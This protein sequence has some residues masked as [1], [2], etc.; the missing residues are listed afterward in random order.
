MAANEHSTSSV[1]RRTVLVTI[2][3]NALAYGGL[4]FMLASFASLVVLMIMLYGLRGMEGVPVTKIE[5]P[6]DYQAYTLRLGDHYLKQY[7]PP[8]L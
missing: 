3:S 4:A 1:P 2:Q 5:T 7:L 6:A 8:L